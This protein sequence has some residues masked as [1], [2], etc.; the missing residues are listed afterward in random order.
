MQNCIFIMPFSS[1]GN[2]NI[3][4]AFPLWSFQS[5]L[6]IV[7]ITCSRE[8]YIFF[9]SIQVLGGLKFIFVFQM[10]VNKAGGKKDY[11]TWASYPLI[12]RA[13]LDDTTFLRMPL[14]FHCQ[15]SFTDPCL[16]LCCRGRRSSCI[17]T[18]PL[19]RA[20]MLLLSPYI[21]LKKFLPSVITLQCRI[22]Y[23][24]LVCHYLD[25][26]YAY[27]TRRLNGSL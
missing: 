27:Q 23:S 9:K 2:K 6:R 3:Y 25:P 21:S 20:Q 14:M 22:I 17:L 13:K 8:G 16:G 10:L 7:A 24:V 12:F 18:T 4:V 15:N 5:P 19:S 26:Q 11:L 1:T